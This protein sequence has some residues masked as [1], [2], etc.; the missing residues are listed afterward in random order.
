MSRPVVTAPS[1]TTLGAIAQLM[2]EHRIGCVVIVDPE[3]PDRVVGIVTEKDF[4]VS[5]LSIPPTSFHWTQLF[6]HFVSSERSLE[7]LYSEYRDKP[8]SE[9]LSAPAITIDAEA[10]VFEAV[11]VMVEHDL[12][13]LPV[14]DDD[15][16]V[17]IVARHDLLKLIADELE[18]ISKP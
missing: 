14:L 1:D 2:I 15:G 12:K 7:E 8:A 11:Q 10:T 6:D 17:G 9:I 3:A 4:D 16:L 18:P 13:R 5:D